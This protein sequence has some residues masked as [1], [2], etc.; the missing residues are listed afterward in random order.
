M[1]TSVQLYLFSIHETS[2]NTSTLRVSILFGTGLFQS[3]PLVLN[4]ALRQTTIKPV[5]TCLLSTLNVNQPDFQLSPS[6]PSFS[7]PLCSSQTLVD[8]CWLLPE[9]RVPELVVSILALFV[10]IVV[11]EL[12]ACYRQKLPLPIPI[13]L[14]VVGPPLCCLLSCLFHLYC[15]CVHLIVQKGAS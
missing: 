9:T 2:T 15:R 6:V 13:E 10:L 7:P 11:K 5:R 8:I 1:T 12:N 14:I 4:P 3:I